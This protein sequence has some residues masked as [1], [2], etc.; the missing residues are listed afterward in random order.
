MHPIARAR[1]RGAL[2]D[3]LRSHLYS[4]RPCGD[5]GRELLARPEVRV[6]ATVMLRQWLWWGLCTREALPGAFLATSTHEGPG[7]YVLRAEND[8][9]V[10]GYR[11]DLAAHL[12]SRGL[13]LSCPAIVQLLRMAGAWPTPRVLS[14][15]SEEGGVD[16]LVFDAW[17]Q[18]QL[19]AQRQR[20]E[21]TSGAFERVERARRALE[22]LRAAV[23]ADIGL[24]AA[25]H[26]TPEPSPLPSLLGACAARSRAPPPSRRTRWATSR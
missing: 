26:N 2:A 5:R 21:L 9:D 14:L 22:M 24:M 20:N 12:A 18:Q 23:V 7:R 8:V 25:A 6:A 10:V 16:R 19:L 4:W 15:P 11:R 1:A 3:A 13:D 17:K